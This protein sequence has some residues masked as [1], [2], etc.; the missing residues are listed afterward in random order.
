MFKIE[1]QK[2]SYLLHKATDQGMDNKL[3]YFQNKRRLDCNV[4]STRDAWRDAVIDR[5]RAT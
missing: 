2:N 1:T 3:Y 5:N 4:V